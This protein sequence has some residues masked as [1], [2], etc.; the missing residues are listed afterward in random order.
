MKEKLLELIKNSYAPY[1][2]L[3]FA[4]IVETEDGSLFN[5]VNIENASFGG[6]ICAERNAINNAIS[7]GHKKFKVL[8][9]MTDNEDICYP[10]NI[11]KQT[12]LEFFDDKVLFNFMTTNGKMEVLT[13]KEVMNK[14]FSKEDL[15]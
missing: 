8:Y 1:S 14:I 2:K 9:L 7:N 5:G 15:K 3:H 11:C 12:F 4:C 6:T 13:Y 10:C